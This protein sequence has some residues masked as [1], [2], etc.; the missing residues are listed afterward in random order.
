MHRKRLSELQLGEQ[1][2]IISFSKFGR[3]T[4]SQAFRS[5][6]YAR[7]PGYGNSTLTYP[8]NIV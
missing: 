1:A 8:C 2:V 6:G 3:K 5:W 7:L 4:C